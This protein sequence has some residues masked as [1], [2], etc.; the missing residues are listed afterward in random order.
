MEEERVSE[1]CK[2]RHAWKEQ[3]D[4]GV[5]RTGVGR[6]REKVEGLFAAAYSIDALQ[7]T[8][9]SIYMFH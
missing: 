7:N 6:E 9:A 5:F 4:C 2:S 1:G 8:K 3:A